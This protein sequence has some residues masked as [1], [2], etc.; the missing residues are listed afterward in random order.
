MKSA[1]AA[2]MAGIKDQKMSGLAKVVKSAQQAE[3][4]RVVVRCR[5]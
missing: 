4:V 3:A 1:G 2:V 5:P